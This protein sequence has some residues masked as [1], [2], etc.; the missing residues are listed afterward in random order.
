MPIEPSRGKK[1]HLPTLPTPHPPILTLFFHLGEG[2]CRPLIPDG[3]PCA[4][5]LGPRRRTRALQV[6][7]PALS[8]LCNSL[9]LQTPG[10]FAGRF[11]EKPGS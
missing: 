3:A 9:I 5:G 7:A 2:Q 8:L 11:K 1:A 10:L 4:P 6:R